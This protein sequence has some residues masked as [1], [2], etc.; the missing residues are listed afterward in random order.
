M[1]LAEWK[2]F[3]WTVTTIIGEQATMYTFGLESEAL[4]FRVMLHKSLTKMVVKLD[5]VQRPEP[6]PLPTGMV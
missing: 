6:A 2:K 1:R 3:N 4:D 5:K